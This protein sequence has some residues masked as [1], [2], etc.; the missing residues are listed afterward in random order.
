MITYDRGTCRPCW[1]TAR[2]SGWGKSS[3]RGGQRHTQPDRS[4][5]TLNDEKVLSN[6]SWSWQLVFVTCECRLYGLPYFGDV[7]RVGSD[8]KNLL[9]NTCKCCHYNVFTSNISLYVVSW[10]TVLW[11]FLSNWDVMFETNLGILCLDLFFSWRGTSKRP[12][13]HSFDLILTL[14]KR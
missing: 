3:D 9:L 11:I 12:S 6:S 10:T 14:T 4:R 13:G 2:G 7:S 8:Y 1:R 5:D